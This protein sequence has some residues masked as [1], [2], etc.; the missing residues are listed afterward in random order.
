LLPTLLAAAE[1]DLDRAEA[2]WAERVYS[3]FWEAMED[4]LAKLHSFETA[5]HLISNNRALHEKEA[6]VLGDVGQPFTLGRVILPDTRPTYGRLR[7][8]YRRAQKDSE[9][10]KIYEQRRTTSALIA[11]FR[12]LGDAVQRLGDRIIQSIDDVRSTVGAA[13]G[14]LEL[15]LQDAVS[16]AST[17]REALLTELRQSSGIE[18]NILRQLR[19]DSARQAEYERSA[20]QMLDNI[21]RRRNPSN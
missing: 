20:K 3:P 4:V 16:Q 13:I 14:S 6:N 5:L 21:Q 9:F 8:L 7:D 18:E 11:G 17:Q 10:A 15:S 2:E 19:D 12:S 1:L